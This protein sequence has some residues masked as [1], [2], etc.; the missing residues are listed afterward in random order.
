[1]TIHAGCVSFERGYLLASCAVCVVPCGTS[2]GP[3]STPA[4][5]LTESSTAPF[6]FTSVA[7]LVLGGG[8]FWQELDLEFVLILSLD[9]CLANVLEEREMSNSNGGDVYDG[10]KGCVWAWALVVML[11]LRRSS[12]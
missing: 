4:S 3:S 9:R 7:V 2:T 11:K 8:V 1:M 5:S 6:S 10:Q 12:D